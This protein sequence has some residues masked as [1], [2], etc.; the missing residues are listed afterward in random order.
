LRLAA[1][2]GRGVDFSSGDVTFFGA[3][4]R[5]CKQR[6]PRRMDVGTFN[7]ERFGVMAGVALMR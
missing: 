3:Q 4:L 7:G 1:I 6:V 2:R 5:P